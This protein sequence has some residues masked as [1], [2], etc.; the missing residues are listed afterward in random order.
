MTLR[1]DT[2]KT[3]RDKTANPTSHAACT[4]HTRGASATDVMPLRKPAGTAN[5]W[6]RI[7]RNDGTIVATNTVAMKLVPAYIEYFSV[8]KILA[9][10]PGKMTAKSP[11]AKK[12]TATKRPVR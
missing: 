4:S 5:A 9:T 6:V 10:I 8:K 11:P 12:K 3:R 7:Q 1:T 2:L